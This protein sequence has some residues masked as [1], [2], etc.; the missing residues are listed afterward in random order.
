MARPARPAAGHDRP[1][2]LG[3]AGVHP[4]GAAKLRAARRD[5]RRRLDA[6]DRRRRRRQPR[7]HR[8]RPTRPG[9][10]S[11]S[12][13]APCTVPTAT[14]RP[15]SPPCGPPPG[16][17]PNR[18]ERTPKGPD[19]AVPPLALTRLLVLVLRLSWLRAA[20]GTPLLP[21][22]EPTPEQPR[23]VA[24]SA[25][26]AAGGPVGATARGRRRRAAVTAAEAR[27]H[28]RPARGDRRGVRRATTWRGAVPDEGAS[29]SSCA[30]TSRAASSP[31]RTARRSPAC[32]SSSTASELL[33]ETDEDGAYEL[34]GVPEGAT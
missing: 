27:H 16:H 18:A 3:R 23:E 14:W 34:A 26:L 8:R 21:T 32:A 6:P 33:T 20:D 25:S 24:V 11:S 22:P 7:H 4:R 10:T 31:T 2:R 1:S 19:P 5:R 15:R 17:A 13:A 9:G 28:D 12:S 30:T 29:A